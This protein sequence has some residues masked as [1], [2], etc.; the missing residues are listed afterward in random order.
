MRRHL[1]HKR[2]LEL[3]VCVQH[4]GPL[5][6]I[7]GVIAKYRIGLRGVALFLVQELLIQDSQALRCAFDRI[8]KHS[9]RQQQVESTL[10]KSRYPQ[11]TPST[12]SLEKSGTSEPN[13]YVRHHSVPRT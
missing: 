6:T 5:K 12:T 10:Y 9:R 3:L 8:I 4:L 2:R 7:V 13:T 1:Y 11:N